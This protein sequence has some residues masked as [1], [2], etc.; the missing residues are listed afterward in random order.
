MD[1]GVVDAQSGSGRFDAA[2]VDAAAPP[3][4]TP[5]VPAF[6]DAAL[7]T[8]AAAVPI[9]PQ[10]ALDA[11]MADSNVPDAEPL[12]RVDA[13]PLGLDA[14]VEAGVDQIPADANLGPHKRVFVTQSSYTGALGGL[15]GADAICQQLADAA[16]LAGTFKAWLS[17]ISESAAA[18]I[19]HATVPY[20]RTDGALVANDWSDLIDGQLVAPINLSE[21]QTVVYGDVWTGTLF[22]G[23]AW[24]VSDC[25]GFTAEAID[26]DGACGNAGSTN[27]QW[28]DQSRPNCFTPLHLYCVEQ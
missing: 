6:Q 1:A 18:R 9:T 19:A 8:D 25:T 14:S 26:Q 4:E 10:L 23:T 20:R 24:S 17:S 28:T 27:S 16:A 21:E 13:A 15:A 12:Q 22:D 11:S 3:S 2:A 5:R 7:R